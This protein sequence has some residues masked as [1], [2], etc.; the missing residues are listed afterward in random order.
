MRNNCALI[1]LFVISFF[2]SCTPDRVMEIE[3]SSQPIGK[4]QATERTSDFTFQIN[5]GSAIED[6]NS[7]PAIDLLNNRIGDMYSLYPQ[8]HPGH[9]GYENPQEF[10]ERI[11][12]HGLKWMRVS[13]DWFDGNEVEPEGSYSRHQVHPDQNAAI[14]ALIEKGIDVNYVLVYWDDQIKIEKGYS[15]FKDESEIQRYLDYV[16]FIVKYFKGRIK[17]YSILNEPDLGKG[18]QQYVDSDEYIELIKRIVPV[19][20]EIDPQAQIIIG[21]LSP[22]IWPNSIAYMYKII[23]SDILPII[24]GLSWHSAG[25]SSPEYMAEEYFNYR[26]LIQN[27]TEKAR[28][29]G[30]TGEFWATEMHWR[31]SDSPHPDEFDGYTGTAAS[32]YLSRSIV[33]HRGYGFNIGLAENLEHIHKQPVIENLAT[34]LAGAEPIDFSID[35]NHNIKNL[36]AYSFIL[37]DGDHLIAIW[38]D[39]IADFNYHGDVVTISIKNLSVNKAIGIDVMN[40][41]QQ[42]LL[43]TSENRKTLLPDLI[44]KDYPLIIWIQPNK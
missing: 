2:S 28:N 14:D 6:F 1:I 36:S 5:N 12:S 13:L 22:L 38:S 7:N 19:I 23:D 21:E 26:S 24:D 41:F 11:N 27:I 33:Q 31:T 10:A 44:I 3:I 40:S 39:A 8:A 16:E 32:K 17:Y 37:P 42:E 34:L 15:R 30:F 20:R 35:E 25:W 29:N 18:T 9:P 43:I 4:E